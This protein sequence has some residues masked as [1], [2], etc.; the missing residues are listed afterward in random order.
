MTFS[1]DHNEDISH[2]EIVDTGV[3][4]I[5]VGGIFSFGAK[6]LVHIFESI[7][8]VVFFDVF[9]PVKIGKVPFK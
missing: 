2:S 5:E 3:E 9:W 6:E 8:L 7:N 4:F 1:V